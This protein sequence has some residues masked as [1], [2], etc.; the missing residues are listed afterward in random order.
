MKLHERLKQI[1]EELGLNLQDVHRKGVCI[2][3]KNRALSYRTL[4]RIEK[5]YIAKF[6]SV[7]RICCAMGIP[8]EKALQGTEL[9]EKM[10]I[11]KKERIDEYTYN[12]K[13][14]ASVVSSPSRSFL[15]MEMTL[16]PGGKTILEQTSSGKRYEKWLYVVSGSLVCHLGNEKFMLAKRD[17]LSFDSSLPHFFVNT[18]RKTCLSILVQNPKGF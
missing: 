5:G 13:V 14:F 15:A 18:G 3:G 4:Q 16:K 7:L 10:V 2:F 17:A 11:R 9:E 8:L 6:S 12:E 1:R